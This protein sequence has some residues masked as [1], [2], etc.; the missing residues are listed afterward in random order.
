MKKILSRRFAPSAFGLA[1]LLVFS[2]GAYAGF[3]EDVND[4]AEQVMTKRQ[5]GFQ[6]ERIY[7]TVTGEFAK[8]MVEDA[9]SQPFYH[10]DEIK[11]RAIDEF[12]NDYYRA[13]VSG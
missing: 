11:E 6:M 1:A 12:A 5:Q 8:A 2:T 10:T 4:L 9:Y 13:C 7:N 3:C